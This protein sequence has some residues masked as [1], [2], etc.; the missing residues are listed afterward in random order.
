MTTATAH[1]FTIDQAVQSSAVQRIALMP[2][3]DGTAAYDAQITFNTGK[4]YTYNVEDDATAQKWHSLL[5]D[6]SD[7]NAISWG[8]EVN[9]AIAHGDIELAS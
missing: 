4:V 8:A 1:P 7:R 3:A 9:R 2:A 6:D 5:S